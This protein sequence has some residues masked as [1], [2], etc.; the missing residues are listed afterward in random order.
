[1]STINTFAEMTG[2]ASKSGVK[3]LVVAYAN[4][5]ETFQ[6]IV[7]AQRLFKIRC[8]LTGDREIIEHGLS[9][10]N[11]D[12][13]GCEIIHCENPPAA[14]ARSI[15]YIR[16][17]KGDILMK[18]SVDTGLM[19]REVLKDTS[20]LKTGRLLSDIFL[21][22]YPRYRENKLVMITDGGMTL[23]PDLLN[24][25]E[26]IR[27]AVEVAHALGNQ[28][29]KVAILSATEFITPKLQ[30]TLDAAVLSKMNERGQITGCIVDGP[31][32]LDNAL[33]EQA[34]KEKGLRSPVAGHAQILIAANIEAANSL[35]KSTAYFADLRMA[36]V[37]IGARVPILIPSRADKSD[38]K[39]FSI[40]LGIIMSEWYRN[41]DGE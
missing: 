35:A 14:L 25:V 6:A 10:H 11:G 9:H 18:G 3:T 12:S 5:D 27:N 41:A 29:P 2:L 31:L 38:T 15:E 37:I 17:G 22:E 8:I 26:L 34:A 4:N 1:M 40:A 39:V 28:T 33:S 36:H 30:S 13:S 20:G 19:M 32:A 7:E 16:D 24:K 23:T 21:L